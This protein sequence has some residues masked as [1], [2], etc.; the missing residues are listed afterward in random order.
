VLLSAVGCLNLDLPDVPNTPPAP[1]LT[2]S[3]PRP[4]DN[5]TLNAQVAASAE[6]V[7]G[8]SS[9]SVLCG[10]LDGGPG[11]TV[12]TWAV[13]PY[14]AMVNFAICQD[15]TEPNPDGGKV[16][17]LQLA[18]RAT[19]DAGGVKDDAV[20]VTFD[21]SGPSLTAQ[22]APT[23]QPKSAFSVTVSS[24]VP[25]RSIPEVLLDL[26]PA[27]TITTVPNS[28][29]GLPTYVASFAST[30]GLGTDNPPYNVPVPQVPI[31]VLTDTDRVVRLTVIG[32]ALSSGNVSELDLS[33][34]LSRVVWDRFIPGTPATSSPIVWAAEPVAFSGGLMLPLATALPANSGSAWLPG[35]LDAFDGTFFG[36]DVTNE[37]LLPG[38]LAGGYAA[39]GLNA[40][41]QTL[42]VRLVGN[43]SSLLLA[44]PPPATSPLPT[45]PLLGGGAVPPLTAVDNLLCLQDSVAACSTGTTEGLTCFDPSLHAVTATSAIVST[46]P[47]A[48]GVVAGAGGRYLSPN[49]AVCGS[50]WNLVDLTAGTVSFGSVADP[51]GVPTCI[52][53]AVSKLFAVGDGTFVVQLSEQCGSVA[54]LPPE[55]PIL[56]VGEDS[57]ILGGYTAPLGSPVLLQ[58]EVV[59]ALADGRVVTLRNA[60]PNTVFEL[61]SM[62]STTPDVTTPI[63]GLFDSADAVLG[64]VLAKSSYA[65]AD[66]SFAVLLSGNTTFGAAVAAFAPNLQP[67]WLY[68]Y[69]RLA[70]AFTVRLV[71]APSV[72][73]VYLVDAES[74]RAVSLRVLPPPQPQPQPDAGP[75]NRAPGIYVVIRD[76]VLVFPL[77][78]SGNTAPLRTITGAQTG[79]SQPIGAAMDSQGNLYVA[80]RN[81]ST[82][83]VYPP[84][85]NGNVAPLRTLTATGMG[86]PEAVALAVGDDVFVA[87]CPTCAG[88]T[89]GGNTGVF[90]FPAQATTSD[91]N[92]QGDGTDLSTPVGVA[93][94][95]VLPASGGQPLYVANSFGGDVV[96]FSPGASGAATPLST[97]NPGDETAIQSMAYGAGTLFLGDPSL[98]VTLFPTSASGNA[99][100]SSSLLPPGFEYPGGVFVDVTVNPPVVYLADWEINAVYVIQTAGTLPN[101]TLQSVVSIS[102]GSTSLD[103]PLGVLVV[104]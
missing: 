34:E 13:A 3:T 32:T 7:N 91:Y 64:S 2:V 14:V 33:V 36:F 45:A 16:P 40:Q 26:Q 10:S 61:W 18:V 5:I 48:V 96:T 46:G 8:I 38:G 76:S 43:A 39:V 104:K 80:N 41:G 93:L 52:V 51:N 6:S 59:G 85:A 21:T 97:F 42:F 35:R 63:A 9:V 17:L 56:R 44:P 72:P 70:E 74:N 12:F 99:T 84:L 62:N 87:T 92:I 60:P 20:L 27:D 57:Q 103:E 78:A 75:G 101:L 73:D 50:S 88:D 90:H 94:G 31:E 4:G 28:D 1:S 95:D 77:N 15:V 47:P 25:L 58:R 30:P 71:S 86:A 69:P 102:G 49:V 53:Q 66:G 81:G 11:H 24:D 67:R 19:T 82:V 22:F 98:G 89:P 54:A 83:T 100:A 68:L 29:G 37:T 65:G 55:F 79:L 23:V